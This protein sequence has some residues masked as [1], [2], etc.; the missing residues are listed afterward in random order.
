MAEAKSTTVD[1][2]VKKV[3]KVKAIVLT[4]SIEEAAAL[5]A[6]VGMISGSQSSPRKYTSDIYYALSAAGVT[7]GSN[8]AI[9][10]QLEGSMN[11]RETP[12]PTLYSF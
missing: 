5:K 2:E 7:N 4:L 6:V 3:E 12:H 8:S 9:N 10:R 11:W 1:K